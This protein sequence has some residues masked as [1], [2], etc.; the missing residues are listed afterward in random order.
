MTRVY[1]SSG[2]DG[3]T[4]L[5]GETRVP[6]YHPQPEAYGSV[7]EASAFLGLARAWTNSTQVA[8]ITE[9]IQ[10]DLHH[11]M[12]ELAAIPRHREKFHRVDQERV[13]WLE[14]QIRKFSQT[15][16]ISKEFVAFGDSKSGA[17]F[18]IARTVVRRAE[19]LVAKLHI[20]GGTEYGSILQYLNRL[21]SLCFV[22]S[23]W[24]TQNNR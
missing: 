3:Y 19:R 23:L 1:S 2:D 24:E 9:E 7:D 22:L 6:K 11:L 17:A 21:S 13:I 18:N 4:S 5:L 12:A 20:E 10:Q 8:S 16:Q 14:D 15:I